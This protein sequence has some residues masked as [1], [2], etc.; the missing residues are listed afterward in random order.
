[1]SA[2]MSLGS[3]AGPQTASLWVSARTRDRWPAERPTA[4]TPGGPGGTGSSCPAPPRR[5]SDLEQF[6][7][8][9][10]ARRGTAALAGRHAGQ[11]DELPPAEGRTRPAEFLADGVVI[12][13]GV[14]RAIL[15]DGVFQQQRE[16]RLGIVAERAVAVH[17]R[18]G[19]L[20]LVRPDR[21][22][23]LGQQ[24]LGVG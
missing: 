15:A 6:P 18:R 19:D 3:A 7:G 23:R 20:L 5:W 11:G 13:F 8:L 14:Q 16:H 10:D 24:P 12:L 22:F 17:Q 1:Q 21:G 9:G 2:P 4:W